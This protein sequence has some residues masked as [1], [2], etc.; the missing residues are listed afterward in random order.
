MYDGGGQKPAAFLCISVDGISILWYYFFEKA[1]PQLRKNC[2]AFTRVP[3]FAQ[4][5]L[6]LMRY[7]W[8]FC[9]LACVQHHPRIC[10]AG[11]ILWQLRTPKQ[12]Q[13]F[14]CLM[15]HRLFFCHSALGCHRPRTNP[16]LRASGTYIRGILTESSGGERGFLRGVVSLPPLGVGPPPPKDESV[17]PSVWDVHPGD[18]DRIIW[19][20]ARIFNFIRKKSGR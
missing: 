9:R 18:L 7:R 4:K 5:R 6:R 19:S 10:A 12:A 13:S 15:R 20:G 3:D 16:L 14:L 2:P 11:R 17:A 8:K 1:V